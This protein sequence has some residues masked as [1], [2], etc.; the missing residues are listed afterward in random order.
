MRSVLG[1]VGPDPYLI[2]GTVRDNLLYANPRKDRISDKEIWEAL[3]DAK[4]DDFVRRNTQGL[5]YFMNEE[6]QFST[7]Q[8]QRLALAR[9]FLRK[10]FLLV[11][12]EATANLDH[13]T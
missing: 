5:D 13:F 7:G 3:S 8:K 4:A 10:P 9:A 12:D 11:L 6:A 2:P 1:Y